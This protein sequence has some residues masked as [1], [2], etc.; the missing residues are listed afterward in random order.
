MALDLPAR[1]FDLA[2]PGRQQ[3][4]VSCRNLG[5]LSTNVIRQWPEVRSLRH[6]SSHHQPSRRQSPHVDAGDAITNTSAGAW[7]STNGIPFLLPVSADHNNLILFRQLMAAN[8]KK[9]KQKQIN[10]RVYLS[11]AVI[12]YRHMPRKC[13]SQRVQN[14][15]TFE[16]H[17]AR[18]SNW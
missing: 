7:L 8:I 10:T 13:Q 14:R 15:R 5:R 4:S 17:I 3:T 11:T 9:Q 6:A 1:S 16:Q 18:L 12:L 2:R